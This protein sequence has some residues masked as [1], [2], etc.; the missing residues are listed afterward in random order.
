MRLSRRSARRGEPRLLWVTSD[1]SSP[2]PYLI[3]S[4]RRAGSAVRDLQWD[5]PLDGQRSF[6]R[7]VEFRD[8]AGGRYPM[9]VKLVSPRLL[10]EFARAR[11]DTVV[12]Q[13][14][15]LVGLYAGLSK[16]FRPHKVICLVEGD[17]S[18]IGRTGN[19]FLKV[20]VRRLA[21][22]FVDVFVANN[23]PA[24]EYVIRTLN[25]PEACRPTSRRIPRPRR[26][27]PRG[28]R[29]SSVPAS[30]SRGRAPTW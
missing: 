8:R 11:E 20:V 29:C 26:R 30:S 5:V 3:E 18:H 2:H 4:C 17:Y 7:L 15:G 25:V 27:P 1:G 23:P 10:L 6:G 24:R 9:S 16:L 21:A 13:E 22:R 14:L 19:A 28:C 12:I